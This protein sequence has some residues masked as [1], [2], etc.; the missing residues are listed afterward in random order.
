MNVAVIPNENY[1]CHTVIQTLGR[2][3]EDLKWWLI[4]ADRLD[5][6]VPWQAEE[7]SNNIFEGCIENNIFSNYEPRKKRKWLLEQIGK[8]QPDLVLMFT[9]KNYS[10]RCIRSEFPN[11]RILILQVSKWTILSDSSTAPS[12]FRKRIYNVVKGGP[13]YPIK[14][15]LFH[16]HSNTIYAIWS[17]KYLTNINRANLNYKVVGNFNLDATLR[18]ERQRKFRKKN[19]MLEITYFT[20]PIHQYYDSSV[21]LKIIEVLCSI[22]SSDKRVRINIK[23]HPR[24]SVRNYH[25]L[26]NL[27]SARVKVLDKR[28]DLNETFKNTDILLTHFSSVID[29]GIAL[30]IP[31][32][33]INP[34]GIF[35]NQILDYIEYVKVANSMNDIDFNDEYYWKAELRENNRLE[36]L[37]SS[38]ANVDGNSFERLFKMIYDF[39][40]SQRI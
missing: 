40:L 31:I 9:S 15:A 23:L 7:Q 11:L 33:C 6:Q 18:L 12:N 30:N 39:S 2:S 10:Y 17:E 34:N 4:D 8:L 22:L 28:L 38:V 16:E 32:L 3:L 25:D 19:G 13:V 35:D 36:Y 29:M 20:Q 24:D 5:L 26:I 37:K 21:N 14:H 1:L 27:S